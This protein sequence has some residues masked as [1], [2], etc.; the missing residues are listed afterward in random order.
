MSK[1]G[2]SK[3]LFA[4]WKK[5]AS[6]AAN[7]P[8]GS[9]VAH[10]E[11]VSV[12]VEDDSNHNNLSSD[13]NVTPN[14]SCNIG[15]RPTHIRP[16]DGNLGLGDA[17]SSSTD[18]LSCLGE[19]VTLEQTQSAR[20]NTPTGPT[21]RT[22]SKPSV[23]RSKYY[24]FQESWR[25]GNTWLRYDSSKNIMFCTVCRSFDKSNRR[26]TFRDTGCSS[27]RLSNVDSHKKSDVHKAAIQ[28]E[29]A[30]KIEKKDRPIERQVTKM[31][32]HQLEKM[33]KYFKTSFFIAQYGKPFSD[34]KLLMEL[35]LHNFGDDDQSKLYT[36]YLSDK[37]C[38]EFIDHI[39]ADILEK[40]VTT[41]LNDDCF[42]SILAD[43]STDRSNTEQEII[44]VSMLNNNRAVTQFVTLAS[45]P[46]ANA[47]NIAKE[48]IV[49]LTDKLK[50]KNWKNNLVSCCFDGA[51]VNLGCK[52][53]VAVRLTEGAPH[54][55]S[56]HCCAHRLELAIKN[57]EEPLIT[58]VE[59][60][61]QDCY[62]FYRWSVKNWG[63][64]QK[65][66]SLL[67]IS[68]KR[69]AKLIGVRLLAHHYRAINAVRF[70]WP[71]I[72]THLNNVGSSCSADASLKKR[73]QAMTLLD[74]LR[75]LVFVFLT[76]FLCSYFA[77]LKEMSLTLQ[78]NDITVDQVVDKVQCVKK[79]L[80]KLKMEKELNETIHKDVQIITDTDNK[81][82][83]TYHGEMIGIS[84]QQN[85][86]KRSQSAKMKETC[87]ETVNKAILQVKNAAVKV[88]DETVK[89][90][91]DRFESFTNHKVI[92]AAAIINPH[93]WPTDNEIDAYG[94]EQL[95]DIFNHYQSILEARHVNLSAA[96]LQWLEL[97]RLILRK[98]R[99]WKID[100]E[101]KE[102]GESTTTEMW[103]SVL[104]DEELL[105]RFDQIFPII[106]ILL[107]LPVH[108]AEL[109]RGFSQMNVVM[110]EKRTNLKT[111]S[112]N[113]LLTI[114]LSNIDYM[115]YDPVGAILKWSPWSGKRRRPDSK[116]YGKRPK[117]D[118]G[119]AQVSE[120]A[121]DVSEAPGL[122]GKTSENMTWSSESD[123][124]TEERR[125]VG[126]GLV[127]GGLARLALEFEEE[128]S[129]WESDDSDF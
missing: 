107:V 30:S 71:A 116:P 63:E 40:N 10:G 19:D 57:I 46:Q 113:S 65:V 16:S 114:K 48:L 15:P 106:R 45:V 9:S 70:N 75:A 37:Q 92:R 100:C 13:S 74:M 23:S 115:T 68:V 11:N 6:V 52:S 123:P 97:K 5:N 104:G 26:N 4:F 34:F 124:E 20:L 67:K 8:S 79:S 78:K 77:I 126:E 129:A 73:E 117:K 82:K 120:A 54:I 41:Q 72:V 55:I 81:I 127:G 51:S 43:G 39:A 36:S 28:A 53:G 56:V 42:I 32:E 125:E 76:N 119:T 89:N 7:S 31:S 22:H 64:L 112:L 47:E 102:D 69:P 118:F 1:P 99:R 38:K 93:N 35:Q 110:N 80:L 61:V 49:T 94:D 50:L 21:K 111:N 98:K 86:E 27:F 96:K 44:F 128:S 88:I 2:K 83:V 17:S 60:V 105:T 14:S 25:K 108:T 109:E 66:G 91:D 33:K 87:A 18:T 59:K 29:A 24:T 103:A 3:T 12:E 122:I 84:A 62:L 121:E 85:R 58:E 90:I 101:N 95:T